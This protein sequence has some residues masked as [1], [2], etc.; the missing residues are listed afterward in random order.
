MKKVLYPILAVVIFLLMQSLSGLLYVKYGDASITWC[1]ML[2]GVATATVLSCLRFF[3][4]REAFNVNTIDWH[5]GIVGVAAT[6]FG[7]LSLD[8]TS[9]IAN[10]PDVMLEEFITMSSTIEGVL[11]IAVISP[12]VEEIVFRECMLGQLLRYGTNRWI[13][14]IATSLVFGIIHFNPIQIPF[15]AAMGVILSIIYYKSGNIVLTSI[16]HILNNSAAVVQMRVLGDDVADFSLIDWL[17]GNTASAICAAVS[18]AI[19]V[20]LLRQFWVTYKTQKYET[21]F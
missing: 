13:A 18:M 9:E 19:C 20:V 11:C 3:R 16:I 2:S 5:T 15:A 4:W 12:I 6:I 7:V 1:V 14:I 17:G 10:L 21:V 8:I